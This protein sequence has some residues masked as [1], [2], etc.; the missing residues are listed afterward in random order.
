MENENEI[1]IDFKRG[2]PDDATRSKM[3]AVKMWW[4]PRKNDEK[5]WWEPKNIDKKIPVWRGRK[6][7]K[8]IEVAK[9]ICAP[10]VQSKRRKKPLK[11]YALK[12]KIKDIIS[13][14]DNQINIL[15]EQLKEYVNAIM[16]EG[17][18]SHAGTEV[19]GSQVSAWKDCLDFLKINLMNIE[20]DKQEFELIFE[21]SLPCTSHRRPDVFLLTANKVII[22]EFK[23][24]QEPQIDGHKDDVKQAIDYKEYIENHHKVSKERALNVTSY[25]VC[26]QEGALSGSLRGIDIITNSNF[27]S[28][29]EEELKGEAPCDFIDEWTSSI[30]T[31]SVEMLEAI[32]TMY[33]DGKIPYISDI[34]D[35]CWTKVLKY[36]EKA[37][38]QRKKYLILINGVPGS[39][40]TAVGQT[41]VFEEN[42]KAKTKAE[43]VYLSGNGPLVEVLQYQ[44]NQVNHKVEV[45]ESS[46]Q[47]IK[48]Y[49]KSYVNKS[50]APEQ[51]VLVFDEAQRAWD[52]V[53]LN[54]GGITEPE[55]L[56][57]IGDNIYKERGYAVIIGLYGN[58]QVIY[59]GEEAGLSLWKDA[60]K[61]EKFSD[62][63]VIASPNISPQNDKN[64]PTACS[65]MENE[66]GERFLPEEDVFLSEACRTDFVNCNN[67]VEQAIS[68]NG[69]EKRA[70]NELMNIQNT[71][72][73]LFVTRDMARVKE[74]IN[75]IQSEHPEYKYGI[76]ISNFADEKVIKKALPDWHLP[77]YDE[78]GKLVH[79]EYVVQNGEY[80]SWYVGECTL[81]EKACTV[82]GNQGL[83]LDYPIVLFGGEY[84]RKDGKWETNGEAYNKQKK[85][86]T[87]PEAIAENN[88]RVL[89]TRARHG[90]I[91]VVPND[92]DLDETYQYFVKMGMDVL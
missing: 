59:K 42:A 63:Y 21:Y 12:V 80:G 82:F 25:L 24:K 45:A 7:A 27:K 35:K 20:E 55:G 3:K 88:F 60:L 36:I 58:G 37:R 64:I 87:N 90:M 77:K 48:D 70:K 8:T 1:V 28:V 15:E 62:W 85:G 84:I 83:E 41:I 29:I 51:S 54:M 65:E 46:I 67:W 91:L 33:R 40:K 74:R 10:K 68:K 86:Y 53:K 52:A 31:E 22:L 56:L 50:K 44:I 23:K 92:P 69:D 47:E 72:M 89:F 9:E 38:E 32:T 81:L 2:F 76:L 4:E 14:N 49:L 19:S 73:Q 43:A 11:D 6:N 30:R 34:N 61:L 78:N 18:A 26:T 79:T 5:M 16:E 57:A 13:A 75:K 71:S 39:G 17:N 66:L